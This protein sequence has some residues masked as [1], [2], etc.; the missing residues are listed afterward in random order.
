M[1]VARQRLG[2]SLIDGAR[3]SIA[4]SASI[5]IFLNLLRRCVRG[6]TTASAFS[7]EGG[8]APIALDIN[9]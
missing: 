7:V 3:Q 6:W 5:S 8:F 9:F 2:K 1:I 4:T